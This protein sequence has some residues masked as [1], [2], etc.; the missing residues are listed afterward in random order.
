M[1]F[2]WAFPNF[3][4]RL[5]QRAKELGRV[6]RFNLFMRQK[7]FVIENNF[8]SQKRIFTTASNAGLIV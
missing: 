3:L 8:L 5:C 2:F 6:I 1:N 7:S 4:A